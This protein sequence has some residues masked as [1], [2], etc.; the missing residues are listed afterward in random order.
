LANPCGAS[1]LPG[2]P[3]DFAGREA[4]PTTTHC[5]AGNLPRNACVGHTRRDRSR[6]VR[7]RHGSQRHG[8][9]RD[10]PCNHDLVDELTVSVSWNWHGFPGG[11][12]GGGIT[13]IT[14]V[15]WTH[16]AAHRPPNRP[17]L[18]M[19]EIKTYP[20]TIRRSRGL[21]TRFA[22][23]RFCTLL[24]ARA[25][26]WRHC[27]KSMTRTPDLQRNRVSIV[28]ARCHQPAPRKQ[29]VCGIWWRGTWYWC[30]A[31]ATDG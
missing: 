29:R 13:G 6:G 1:V 9:C 8:R 27:E 5:E 15:G 10:H 14:G 31:L 22:R 17:Q 12:A 30:S 26:S 20:M 11:R 21:A 7:V 25:R 3:G 16:Q 28:A 23:N 2:R 4:H 19:S 24:A 18:M